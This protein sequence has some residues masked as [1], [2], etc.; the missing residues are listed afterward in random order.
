MRNYETVLIWKAGLS[1]AETARETSRV[2][3]II[4]GGEGQLVGLDNWGRRQLAYPIAKE[5]EGVYH[6]VHWNGETSVKE[7]IDKMLRINDNCLRHVTL[8]KDRN[9]R[10]GT[11]NDPETPEDGQ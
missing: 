4:T 5:S 11:S 8:R 9:T 7:A 2:Q 1:E 6:L 10:M 3:E